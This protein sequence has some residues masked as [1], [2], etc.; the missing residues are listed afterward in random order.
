VNDRSVVTRTA[1]GWVGV[2]REGYVPGEKTAVVRHTLIGGRKDGPCEPGPSSEVRYFVVPPG[3]VTRLE[4]HEHEHFVIAG[5]G[6]GHAIVGTTVT[7]IAHHDV[8]YVAPWQPHQFVNKGTAPFGFF[9]IVP[10]ARDIS[11]ELSPE[12]LAAL[13]SSPA[14]AY[15]DPHG[16]PPPR[17]RTPVSA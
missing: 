2:E 1:D 13:M 7:E 11:Q 3:A 12:E 8:V 17:K 10:A 6:I 9:C 16:A 14:G 5:E 15:A 4:K